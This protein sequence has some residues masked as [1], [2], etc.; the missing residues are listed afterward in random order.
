M[1][2]IEW[3]LSML[4]GLAMGLLGSIIMAIALRPLGLGEDIVFAI[5]LPLGLLS[6]PGW[7]SFAAKLAGS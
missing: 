2:E 7:A 6:A 5:V 4:V 3:V 1:R